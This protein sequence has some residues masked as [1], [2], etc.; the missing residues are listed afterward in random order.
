VDYASGQVKTVDPAGNTT[1]QRIDASLFGAMQAGRINIVSTAEGAGV[2]VG[3]VQVAG[4]DGVQI[5]SAG[6]LSVSG[7]AIP[8]A[9]T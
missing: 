9:S 8:T 6:D 1:D 5:R 7:Q 2:R 4:R 3:A